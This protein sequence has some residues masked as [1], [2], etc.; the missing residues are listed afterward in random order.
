M[1]VTVVPSG[2]SAADLPGTSAPTSSWQTIPE[3]RQ[4]LEGA[5]PAPGP[6]ACLLALQEASCLV[7]WL[8]PA[9][10]CQ[11]IRRGCDRGEG[12]LLF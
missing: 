1:P 10:L 5:L 12:P 4:E 2:Q 7:Y 3:L 6:P 11:L 8:G 9:T